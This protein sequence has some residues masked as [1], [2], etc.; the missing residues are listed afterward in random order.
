MRIPLKV[1]FQAVGCLPNAKLQV[2]YNFTFS[3]IR[4]ATRKWGQDSTY[5]YES[6]LAQAMQRL[7]DFP[8]AHLLLRNPNLVQVEQSESDHVWSSAEAYSSGDLI[9]QS[10]F[11]ENTHHQHTQPLDMSLIE[12]M[13]AGRRDNQT[14]LHKFYE[15]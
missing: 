9:F 6:Q 15:L 8:E 14:D 12:L 10:Q 7:H 4:E 5:E 2:P 13:F 3:D 1:F 11:W